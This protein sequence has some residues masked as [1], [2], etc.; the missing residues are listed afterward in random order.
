MQVLDDA[1]VAVNSGAAVNIG[2]ENGV[3]VMVLV[4]A[5]DENHALELYRTLVP[6]FLFLFKLFRSDFLASL[7][8]VS[9]SFGRSPVCFEFFECFCGVLDQQEVGSRAYMASFGIGHVAS[10]IFEYGI[11]DFRCHFEIV[12]I[13]EEF[14][15]FLCGAEECLMV[16][17][18]DVDVHGERGIGE[19]L[20]IATYDRNKLVCLFKGSV[21]F[22]QLRNPH[23]ESCSLENC[24]TVDYGF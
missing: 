22:F 6:S 19:L 3:L 4:G 13:S 10:A 24:S 21:R 8:C 2:R 5:G 17:I 16:K 12:K 15:N 1:V 9:R 7:V 18:S 14:H 20:V 11:F 23:D